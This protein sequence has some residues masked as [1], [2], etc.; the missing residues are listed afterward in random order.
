MCTLQA[1]ANGDG[2]VTKDEYIKAATVPLTSAKNSSMQRFQIDVHN[3][4]FPQEEEGEEA[5][6][7]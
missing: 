7:R 6:I 1:D 2:E 3:F 5:I 4:H